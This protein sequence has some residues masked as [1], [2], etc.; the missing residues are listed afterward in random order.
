MRDYYTPRLLPRILGG[1]KLPPPPNVAELNRVQPKVEVLAVVAQSESPGLVTVTVKVSNVEENGK[2]SGAQDLRVFRNGQLVAFKEGPLALDQ[3][4]E[5]TLT[6]PNIQL[7]HNAS[8]TNKSIFTAYA[9]NRE[10]GE[11]PDGRT[12]LSA[13]EAAGAKAEKRLHRL[14]RCQ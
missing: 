11:E 3:N 6:F 9:F 4:G 13:G 5:A 2:Q 10:S 7:A 14:H 12:G 1:E 8:D